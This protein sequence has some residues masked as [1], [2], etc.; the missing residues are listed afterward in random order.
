LLSRAQ[1]LPDVNGGGYLDARLEGRSHM[2]AADIE[3]WTAAI[4]EHVRPQ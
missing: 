2:T 3:T 1:Y 4:D